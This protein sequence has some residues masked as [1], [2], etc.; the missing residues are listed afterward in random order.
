MRIVL[1][2]LPAVVSLPL[3][4]LGIAQQAVDKICYS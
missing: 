2:I 1:F 4:A 3:R